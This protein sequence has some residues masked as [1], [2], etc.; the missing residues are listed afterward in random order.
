MAVYDGTIGSRRFD[1]FSEFREKYRKEYDK[2]LEHEIK[3]NRDRGIV[4]P[5]NPNKLLDEN[6]E[7]YKEIFQNYL[8]RVEYED[9]MTDEDLRR[10]FDLYDG[11]S[12][13]ADYPQREQL[14]F[15]DIENKFSAN[16]FVRAGNEEYM[17]MHI[18]LV[19]TRVILAGD[20]AQSSSYSFHR[21]LVGQFYCYFDLDNVSEYPAILDK[22]S[23]MSQEE[24]IQ[25]VKLAEQVMKSNGNDEE[26][27]LA[28]DKLREKFQLTESEKREYGVLPE[29]RRAALNRQKGI[30]EENLSDKKTE[31]QTESINLSDSL[32]EQEAKRV[33]AYE[34]MEKAGI[35]LSD[36][37]KKELAEL[38]EK[39]SRQAKLNAYRENA[40]ER[41][42]HQKAEM[43][44]RREA[45]EERNRAW[46]ES[47]NRSQEKRNSEIEELK[48]ELAVLRQ[49]VDAMKNVKNLGVNL[50]EEQENTLNKNETIT[51]GFDA[52]QKHE[53]EE[54]MNEEVR[55]A[56]TEYYEQQEENG[57]SR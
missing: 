41:E 15:D 46:I 16:V 35:S 40:P 18:M 12:Q 28:V 26:H 43:N 20:I 31:T 24:L 21:G 4:D 5:N 36:E 42:E 48:A 8:Q 17:N 33:E 29:Q 6:S 37:Q 44:A 19:G 38:R 23:K 3:W 45:N 51:K 22:V 14:A 54:G 10:L 13:N 11:K 9:L 57:R 7:E 34:T 56:M 52:I 50:S 30:N 39:A 32:S 47:A 2:W 25:V 1:T 55:K 27:E 49:Q 53:H